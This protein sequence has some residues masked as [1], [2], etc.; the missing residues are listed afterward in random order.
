MAAQSFAPRHAPARCQQRSWRAVPAVAATQL[1][2]A[3][4]R[5]GGPGSFENWRGGLCA[6]IAAAIDEGKKTQVF[7]WSTSEVRAWCP[8]YYFGG[9]IKLEHAGMVLRFSFARP[10]T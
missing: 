1:H 8:W 10:V 6:R 2:D 3:S 7:N 5:I 4:Q 9:G